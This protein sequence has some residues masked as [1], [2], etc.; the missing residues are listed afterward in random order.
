MFIYSGYLHCDGYGAYDSL[1]SANKGVVQVGCWY[2]MRRKFV[3]AAKVSKKAGM[4]DWFIKQIGRLSKIERHI[5]DNHCLPNLAYEHRQEHAPPII[6]KI[7]DKLDELYHK[8]PPQSLLGKAITYALNQWPKLLTYLKD[9]RLEISN[10]RMEQ[11]IKPFAVGRKN[12]CVPLARNQPLR[13]EVM[14]A[15]AALEDEGRSFEYDN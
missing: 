9:G 11:A 13:K 7:R 5:K 1:A 4:A 10:N 15:K 12:W 6:K 8:T 2:H 3:D 14:E